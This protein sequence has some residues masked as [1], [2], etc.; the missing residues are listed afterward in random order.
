[1]S[2]A[3]YKLLT[4]PSA[5]L[6][7]LSS[8]TSNREMLEQAPRSAVAGAVVELSRIPAKKT[9]HAHEIIRHYSRNGV[10]RFR[11]GGDAGTTHYLYKY[12]A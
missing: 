5:S 11:H 8:T 4:R 6:P 10:F 3:N 12:K 7:L 2:V 1:M 9:N